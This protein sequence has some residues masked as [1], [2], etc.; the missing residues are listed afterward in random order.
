MDFQFLFAP[1]EQ[2]DA[3][4]EGL[5]M[6]S[7]FLVAMLIASGSSVK[8]VQARLMRRHRKR[9]T[10]TRTSGR[11]MTS[12]RATLS[13]HPSGGRLRGDTRGSFG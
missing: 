1:V 7:S 11:T 10:P 12:G 2:I 4:L 6:G 3:W 9:G 5:F 8:V 13:T